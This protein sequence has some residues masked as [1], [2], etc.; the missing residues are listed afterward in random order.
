MKREARDMRAVMTSV[1]M[2]TTGWPSVFQS[3]SVGRAERSMWNGTPSFRSDA[4]Y[5]AMSSPSTRSSVS[6]SSRWTAFPV[7][8]MCTSFSP[9][10]TPSAMRIASFAR[11]DARGSSEMMTRVGWRSATGC[12]LTSRGETGAGAALVQRE[13]ALGAV[14]EVGQH[15]EAAVGGLLG[16]RL[17][18]L[19][20]PVRA[21]EQLQSTLG[22]GLDSWILHGR[23]RVIDEVQVHA[24][25]TI[26]R[27]A[28]EA[29]RGLEIGVIGSG[30]HHEA[31]CSFRQIHHTPTV[32]SGAEERQ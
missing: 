15:H 21:H 30:R 25:P 5:F 10:T 26:E 7:S 6:S 3:G 2:G 20:T 9:A 16:E 22:Q 23:D 18:A 29:Q 28:A 14:D 27:G 24:R 12:R 8:T 17:P 31:E 1:V 13:E 32:T 19:L 4:R 11:W